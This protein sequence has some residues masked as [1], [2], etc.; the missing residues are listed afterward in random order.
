M[1]RRTVD[2]GK[3]AYDVLRRS[4]SSL[5]NTPQTQ[6]SNHKPSRQLRPRSSSRVDRP[7]RP[8]PL[9]RHASFSS[10]SAETMVGAKGPPIPSGGTRASST[11]PTSSSPQHSASLFRA[12]KAVLM[13]HPSLDAAYVFDIARLHYTTCKGEE[14]LI[15][16]T[17]DHLTKQPSNSKSHSR[18]NSKRSWSE[19]AE[20]LEDAISG[21][22]GGFKLRRTSEPVRSVENDTKFIVCEACLTKHFPDATA[23]CP[24]GHLFC[25]SCVFRE[26]LVQVDTQDPGVICL[27]PYCPHPFSVSVLSKILPHEPVGRYDRLIENQRFKQI[28]RFEQC[29]R[30]LW[31]CQITVPMDQDPLFRCRNVGICEAIT[32]RVCNRAAH[33]F[34][35]CREVE[36][37]E[38][39]SQASK[40]AGPVQT[41]YHSGSSLTT[42]DAAGRQ[43]RPPQDSHNNHKVQ[44]VVVNIKEEPTDTNPMLVSRPASPCPP[45]PSL[46]PTIEPDLTVSERL[47]STSLYVRHRD[48][49]SGRG[50][51]PPQSL[52][53]PPTAS[54]SSSPRNWVLQKPPL[55]RQHLDRYTT[56]SMDRAPSSAFQLPPPLASLKLPAIPPLASSCSSDDSN[57]LGRP[58]NLSIKPRAATAV[59]P[60]FFDHR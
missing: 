40:A 6:Y 5:S 9:R 28:N 55:E 34:K 10:A 35:T 26:V 31:K 27:A 41:E 59:G 21:P 14:Q 49:S 32:C 43:R 33:G 50:L 48:L 20:T 39:R 52:R 57:T 4:P 37:E 2:P 13:K 36:I 29:P 19:F 54:C 42:L 16:C 23:G 56:M 15:R 22:G 30:C 46:G 45:T 60:Q 53:Y 17:L 51:P 12:V 38:R 25:H 24:A 1:L 3:D 7:V 58:F 47:G 44:T 8:L 11:T 18:R